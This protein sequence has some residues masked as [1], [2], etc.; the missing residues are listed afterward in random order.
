MEFGIIE[1]KNYKEKD[2][3]YVKICKLEDINNE[4]VEINVFNQGK[5]FFKTEKNH[6]E[7]FKSL[8]FRVSADNYSIGLDLMII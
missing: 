2:G 3:L 5:T 8:N 1:Y 7:V 4:K 6:S